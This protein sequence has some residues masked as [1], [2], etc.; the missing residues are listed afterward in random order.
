MVQVCGVHEE[1]R[2]V[3]MYLKENSIDEGP[4]DCFCFP[5]RLQRISRI[6][7]VL[8]YVRSN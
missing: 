5:R 3:E 2:T 8:N 7:A 6:L 4:D 1:N